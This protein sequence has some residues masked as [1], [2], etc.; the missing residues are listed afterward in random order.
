MLLLLA[1]ALLVIVA[2][3]SCRRWL[4]WPVDLGWRLHARATTSA[5][6]PRSLLASFLL[7]FRIAFIVTVADRSARLSRRLCGGPCHSPGADPGLVLLPFWTSVLVRAYAWLVLLQRT[8]VVQFSAEKCRVDHSPLALV[9]QRIRHRA[10]HDPHPFALH[11]P[12]AL[13]DHEEDPARTDL[14]GA[15]LGGSGRYMFPTRLPAAVAARHDRRHDVLVFVLTLGFYITP[16]LLG[17]GRT[18]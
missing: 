14:A 4:A 7:T 6:S 8:G 5:S 12:A 11:G 15:S 17:G 1:P 3:L 10:R 2:L 13:R 16:E 9:Q 18:S